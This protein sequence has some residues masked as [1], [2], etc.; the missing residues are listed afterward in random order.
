MS[1]ALEALQA[2]QKALA[3]KMAKLR[4][5]AKVLA[6]SQREKQS[7]IARREETRKKILI[8]SAT[9]EDMKHD[10]E[11]SAQVTRRM[12]SF[13]TREDDRK[14]FGL[15]GGTKRVPKVAATRTV[16]E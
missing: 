12:S 4:E 1:K 8:G 10:A 6:Q 11:L 13:L 15:S 9:L 5:N 2:K 16:G 7:A 3:A 14:L